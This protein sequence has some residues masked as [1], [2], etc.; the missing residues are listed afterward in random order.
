MDPNEALINKFYSAF[1]QK[2][3]KTMNSCYSDDIIFYDPA[4]E[5]LRGDEARFMWEMLCK[6]A[7]NFSLT[8]GNI[9]KLDDEYYTCDWVATY[10]FSKTGRKVVNNIRANMR[11]ANGEIVEHSDAF[12]LHKWSSQAL[13]FAG[14]LFGWNSFFQRK[15]KN[16]AKKNLLKFIQAKQ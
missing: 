10:T 14:K 4:F 12:S 1:Q 9:I 6:N 8:Y 16:R 5:I 15:I 13:G 7:T 2:D 11:F 3:Y